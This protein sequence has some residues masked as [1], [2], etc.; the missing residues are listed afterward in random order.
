MLILEENFKWHK[1]AFA[2]ELYTYSIYMIN[3]AIVLVFSLASVKKKP[4]I[5]FLGD[6]PLFKCCIIFLEKITCTT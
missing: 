6:L 4:R 1:E 2:S 3:P 5:H